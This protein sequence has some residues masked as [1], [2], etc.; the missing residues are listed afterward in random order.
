MFNLFKKKK[1]EPQ[2]PYSFWLIRT[3]NLAKHKGIKDDYNKVI[4]HFVGGKQKEVYPFTQA[5]VQSIREVYKE[6]ITEE[7]INEEEE[8]EF[9]TIEG[10]G[11]IRV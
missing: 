3:T 11:V 6:P 9:D 2:F 1:E 8:F 4:V 7:I 10:F 5:L